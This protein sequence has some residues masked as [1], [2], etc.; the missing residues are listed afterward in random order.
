M[1]SPEKIIKYAIGELNQNLV[2]LK[3]IAQDQ[4]VAIAQNRQIIELLSEI[5]CVLKN[6][7]EEESCS[8]SEESYSDSSEE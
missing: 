5:L 7:R 1:A 4:S 8:D 2:I 3:T 6:S